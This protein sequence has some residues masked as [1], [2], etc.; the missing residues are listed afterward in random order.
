VGGANGINNSD[1]GTAG[2]DGTLNFYVQ[3]Q[4][5]PNSICGTDCTGAIGSDFSGD[6]GKPD[7]LTILL[8]EP[9]V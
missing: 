7:V 4:T 9:A 5:D 6:A 8:E 2:P 3:G 1:Y